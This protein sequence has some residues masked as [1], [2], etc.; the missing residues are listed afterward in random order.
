MPTYRWAHSACGQGGGRRRSLC[1]P[2]RKA[3]RNALVGAFAGA[4]FGLPAAAWPSDPVGPAPLF[5]GPS[6]IF[7][8]RHRQGERRGEGEQS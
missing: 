6:L 2:P 4:V 8:R 1:R 5:G 3:V 7:P